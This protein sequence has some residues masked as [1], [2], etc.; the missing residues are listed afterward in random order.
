MINSLRLSTQKQYTSYIKRFIDYT[1]CISASNVSHVHV[2]NYLQYLFDS[3]L[4]YASINAASSAVKTYLDML[5]VQL[6]YDLISRFKKGVF[7]MRPSLPKYQEI[8]DPKVVLD[9]LCKFSNEELPT[10]TKKCVTL[11]A[12][13][14]CQR[15][16]TL[17]SLKCCDVSFKDSKAVI[18]IECLQKQSRPGFHQSHVVL[19][20]YTEPSLCIVKCLRDYLNATQSVRVAK[21]CLTGLFLTYG[22]PIKNASTDTIS[23]WIKQTMYDAGVPRFFTAHSTR[24]A[25]TSS[26]FIGGENVNAIMK[27]AGWTSS[28][29]FYKFYNKTFML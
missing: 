8:W 24:A 22:K 2:I 11:L 25:S 9:Y 19:D 16:G 18:R 28:D 10:L 7:N 17:H 3:G 29:T 13:A 15:L 6:N 23:R 27:C 5:G 4:G 20:Q 26:K 12:L 14:S 1:D 21:P